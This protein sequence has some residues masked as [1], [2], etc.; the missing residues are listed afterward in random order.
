LP[1]L[2]KTYYRFLSLS[3]LQGIYV[4]L[5]R[6]IS[7]SIT[8]LIIIAPIP[9]I[10]FSYSQPIFPSKSTPFEPIIPFSFTYIPPI[11]PSISHLFH[12]Y[13]SQVS[14]EAQ[15]AILDAISEVFEPV[16]S[17]VKKV[18]GVHPSATSKA[19]PFTGK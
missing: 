6:L 10:L 1:V 2:I 18:R 16:I 7:H 14:S 8:Y 11:S 13:S 15:G 9:Y 19:S 4:H 5:I 3:A 12:F 17:Q